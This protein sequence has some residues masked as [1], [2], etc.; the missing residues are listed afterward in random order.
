[1]RLLLITIFAGLS[2]F[3]AE[4]NLSSPD[5]WKNWQGAKSYW[6]NENGVLTGETQGLK[7]TN[8][9]HYNKKFA[10]FELTFQ[11][12]FMSKSGNSGVQYRSAVNGKKVK[13]YQADMETGPNY[14]RLKGLM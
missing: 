11:V 8:Y 10:N 13:G 9:I 5:N 4:T 2:L 1:M 7:S 3:S 12:R 6:K 14:L